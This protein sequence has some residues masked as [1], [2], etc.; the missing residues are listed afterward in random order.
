MRDPS[1]YDDDDEGP[2]SKVIDEHS[3]FWDDDHSVND[4]Y[5]DYPTRMVTL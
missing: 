3:T 5:E 1:K 4:G 2:G